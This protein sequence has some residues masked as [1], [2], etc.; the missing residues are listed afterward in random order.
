MG[1]Q[2]RFSQTDR[3]LE[4]VPTWP[5][6]S[7]IL[8]LTGQTNYI[9]EGTLIMKGWSVWKLG[10]VVYHISVVVSCSLDYA[11]FIVFSIHWSIQQSILVI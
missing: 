9:C 11:R 8:L 5:D 4:E 10:R 1:I 7:L 2:E 6:V 3:A